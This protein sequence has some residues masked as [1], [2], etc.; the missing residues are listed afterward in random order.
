MPSLAAMTHLRSIPTSSEEIA[1]DA[2]LDREGRIML[3]GHTHLKMDRMVKRW[4]VLNPGS[5]GM[6]FS[7]PGM[8]EWLLLTVTPEG[9]ETDFRALPY[10][11]E[12]MLADAATTSYP[13]LDF[14]RERFTEAP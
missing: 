2:L 5:V 7:E 9:V 12:S 10:D 4:R 14:L 13:E 11:M 6:S 3:A 1:A 8:V